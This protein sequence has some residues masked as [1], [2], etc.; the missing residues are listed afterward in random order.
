MPKEFW[1]LTE[2]IEIF[3]IDEGFLSDLE[4][5]EIVCPVFSQDSPR[6]LFSENDLAKLRLAKILSEEMG[7]NLPGV[8][9]ILRMRQ[10]MFDMRSQFDDILD[11]LVRN[12]R[13][14]LEKGP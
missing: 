14:T 5:E 7:V 11:D 13:E 10:M 4:E 12:L 6:K 2:V 3:E 1:T 8:E 9:I